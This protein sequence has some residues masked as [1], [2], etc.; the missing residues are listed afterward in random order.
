MSQ[1]QTPKD[2]VD[3]FFN[4]M[5]RGDAEAAAA[6]VAD[7]VVWWVQGKGELTKPQICGA[8][9]GL[10]AATTERHMQIGGRIAEG[11]RIAVEVETRMAFRDG[12]V[13]DNT[14]HL[15]YTV[16]DGKITT[17]REY[18]DTARAQAFAAGK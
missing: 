3:A 16:R 11:D 18:M 6:L 7:E 5:E 15:A 10:I 1:S 14:M 8:H 13:L 9:A 2:I 4:A 12:R 17:V